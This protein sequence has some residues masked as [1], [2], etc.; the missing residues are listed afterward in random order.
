VKDLN[1]R[2]KPRG[3]VQEKA[4]SNLKHYPTHHNRYGEITNTE[5]ET[6]GS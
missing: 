1:T 4:H 6:T 3:N 5:R 2:Q